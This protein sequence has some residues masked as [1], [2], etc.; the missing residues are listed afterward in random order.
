MLVSN[1]LVL[2]DGWRSAT[3]INDSGAR[4]W[5]CL[6]GHASI[7]QVTEQLARE[8]QAPFGVVLADVFDFVRDVGANGLLENVSPPADAMVTAE[9][10]P[11]LATGDSIANVALMSLDGSA[12]ALLDLL[13][14]ETILVNWNPH[15]GYC[16][17]VVDRL[18]HVTSGLEA[19]GVTLVL[20]A[21]GDAES[22]RSLAT[23]AGLQVPILLREQDQDPCR[24]AGTPA[25]FHVD[26]TGHLISDPA[27]GSEDV[28]SMAERMARVDAKSADPR[29]GSGQ[30]V[31]YLLDRGAMCAPGTGKS[32]ALTWAGSREYLI[33]DYHVGIRYDSDATAHI[34]DRL[35]AGERVN[36]PRA[37][38]SF[39]V[40][41][42]P[43]AEGVSGR[44]DGEPRASRSLSLLEQSGQPTL[45]SR[46]TDRVLRALLWRLDDA[47][48]QFGCPPDPVR[49]NAIAVVD[50]RG[51][52]LL[53]VSLQAFAPRL[54]PMLAKAGFALVDVVRPEIDLATAELVVREP[55]VCHDFA[56]LEGLA[57][58]ATTEDR[59]ATSL[60]LSAVLPGRYPLIGWCAIVPGDR[61][62]ARLSPASA[63]AAV[64]SAV[65]GSRDPSDRLHQLAD[66]FTNVPGYGL[67]YHSE[68]DLI[69]VI[70]AALR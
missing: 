64:M 53:P 30:R 48:D 6:D 60:E 16:V 55:T 46:D 22:N 23:R 34:L 57:V 14:D 67:W 35:F 54:Q 27:Y 43:A 36:D 21:Y 42:G 28:S 69:G 38:H 47:I 52:A 51:A 1:E 70:S 32:S 8:Y 66:L 19:A 24:G 11:P 62:V 7:E 45:R 59:G 29:T 3:V 10:I 37:G 4:I 18:A 58:A 9:P 40:A 44:G 39:S 68:A 20:I 63:A 17:S 2:V 56:V 31:R 15:C 33:D 65:E 5:T 12:E 25:A 13:G 50:D 41:L 49:T 26:R 61:S